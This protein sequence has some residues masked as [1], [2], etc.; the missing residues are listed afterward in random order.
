[1]MSPVAVSDRWYDRVAAPSPANMM[2]STLRMFTPPVA[3]WLTWTFIS[4]ASWLIRLLWTFSEPVESAPTTLAR[5]MSPF[6]ALIWLSRLLAWSTSAEMRLSASPLMS[7]SEEPIRL[8]SERKSEIC[9]MAP[10]RLM[11]EAVSEPALV[12]AE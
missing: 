1:M 3:R 7:G 5:V 6:R 4:E 12:K 11:V 10:P 2:P 9:P 8:A